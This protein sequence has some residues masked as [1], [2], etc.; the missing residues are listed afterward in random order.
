MDF[1][2]AKDFAPDNSRKICACRSSSPINEDD[3]LDSQI[4][5]PPI[6]ARRYRILRKSYTRQCRI[7]SLISTNNTNPCWIYYLPT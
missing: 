1:R 2:S 3:A 7:P 5:G 4:D 6:A